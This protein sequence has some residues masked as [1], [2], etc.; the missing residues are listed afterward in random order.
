MESWCC[1]AELLMN[2]GRQDF[3]RAR[4]RDDSLSLRLSQSLRRLG[5]NHSVSSLWVQWGLAWS[6]AETQA[7]RL[8][9]YPTF[10]LLWSALS[11]LGTLIM[12]IPGD[13]HVPWVWVSVREPRRNIWGHDQNTFR[14]K[15]ERSESGRCWFLSQAYFSLPRSEGKSENVSTHGNFK[16]QFAILGGKNVRIN[17]FPSAHF[18]W[19][20]ASVKSIKTQVE[21]P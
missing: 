11:N 19:G 3:L 4:I 2:S 13:F 12:L 21:H 9:A 7:V 1:W 14:W 16:A 17:T 15:W 18:L 5:D 6:V 10:L 20:E 8:G